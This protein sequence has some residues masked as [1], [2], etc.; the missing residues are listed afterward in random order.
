MRILFI[1]ADEPARH[2][3][4]AWARSRSQVQLT[5]LHPGQ[6]VVRKKYEVIV[7]D[8]DSLLPEERQALLTRIPS[9]ASPAVYVFGCGVWP[10][11]R[12]ALRSRG[13]R[14]CRR[15]RDVLIA[16]QV[17]RAA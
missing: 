16:L 8:W 7:V 14:T 3:M 15:L 10:Q 1:A 5:L 9:P 17:A 6:R 13:S 11:Q 12:Q 4:L 2:E